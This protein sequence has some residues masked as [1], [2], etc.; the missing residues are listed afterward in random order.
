MRHYTLYTSDTWKRLGDLLASPRS[1][2]SILHVL[3]LGHVG[4]VHVHYPPPRT[5]R[6][7]CGQEDLRE[8]QG[9][10]KDTQTYA[11][12]HGALD[13]SEEARL[14]RPAQGCSATGTHPRTAGKRA[15]ALHA[16]ATLAAHQTPGAGPAGAAQ[17][18]AGN[19]SWLHGAMRSCATAT[20]SAFKSVASPWTHGSKVLLAFLAPPEYPCQRLCYERDR[21]TERGRGAEHVRTHTAGRGWCEQ[22]M[23][24][25][26]HDHFLHREAR[27]AVRS[28]VAKRWA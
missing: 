20:R 16:E 3:H 4:E 2:V 17:H 28:R 5:H 23:P 11:C 7:A 21:R 26:Q 27:R 10:D 25:A 8:N 13:P 24:R 18:R 19:H 12:R 15:G 6:H 1:R 9:I 14:V 22:E